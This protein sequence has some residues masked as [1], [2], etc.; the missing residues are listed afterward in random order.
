MSSLQRVFR[1]T[2]A[3]TSAQAVNFVITMLYSVFLIRLLGPEQYGTYSLSFNFASVFGV[4]V[5]FG[6]GWLIT[7]QVA[8]DTS[9]ARAL[10][11]NVLPLQVLLGISATAAM[12]LLIALLKY[13]DETTWAIMIAGVGMV[14]LQCYATVHSVFRAFQRLELNSFIVVSERI[15]SAGLGCLLLFLGYRLIPLVSLNAVLTLAQVGLG[16][17]VLTKMVGDIQWRIDLRAWARM[18]LESFPFAVGSFF[19][20]SRLNFGPL[21]LSRIATETDVG[22]FNAAFRPCLLLGYIAIAFANAM[23]PVMSQAGA[24]RE[25]LL[26]IY[27]SVTKVIFLFTLPVTIEIMMMS[28]WLVPF[29]Y[30]PQFEPAVRVLEILIWIVPSMFLIYPMGNVLVAMGKTHLATVSL[31]IS[32]LILVFLN[33]VLIEPYSYVGAAL[34]AV[35][36]EAV[37]AILYFLFIGRYLGK[38]PFVDTILKPT[39]SAGVMMVVAL[40]LRP[41]SFPL[42]VG[43]G[44]I[45]YI[46]TVTFLRPLST[47]DW[48]RLRELK[49]IGWIESVLLGVSRRK[50]A[51]S[52]P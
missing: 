42:A 43:L 31:T 52:R 2:V 26:D 46:A 35:L 28:D 18:M 5:A 49:T 33:L 51:Q 29:V 37:L 25:R 16:L 17:A 12:F 4:F 23:F 40:F 22:F 11:G 1:N 39:M 44:A 7:D 8:R 36:S 38:L 10:L 30:G 47:R 13:S 50:V 3:E 27:R 48:D 34:A 20:A 14:A 21:I 24:S 15:V 32:G 19:M 9:R 41:V 6:F 45:A